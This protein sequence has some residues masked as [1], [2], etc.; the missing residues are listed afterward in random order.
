[1][2]PVAMTTNCAADLNIPPLLLLLLVCHGAQYHCV[3]S[4]QPQSISCGLSTT[5]L[6]IFLLCSPRT[7]CRCCCQLTCTLMGAVPQSLEHVA[8]KGPHP[9]AAPCGGTG[10]LPAPMACSL[11]ANPA[12]APVMAAHAAHTWPWGG[13]RKSLCYRGGRHLQH[14]HAHDIRQYVLD[15][16]LIATLGSCPICITYGPIVRYK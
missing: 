13:S 4:W 3:C 5:H 16:T 1:M 7:C 2:L 9:A 15:Q 8:P 12:G 11:R 10:S 6:Y 14:I